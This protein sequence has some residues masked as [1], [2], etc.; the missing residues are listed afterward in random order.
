MPALALLLLQA[1]Q[2]A[3]LHLCFIRLQLQQLQDDLGDV[4]WGAAGVGL[5]VRIGRHGL[6]HSAVV[7]G[8]LRLDGAVGEGGIV[9]AS[10]RRVAGHSHGQGGGPV[11]AA[12]IVS[13]RQGGGV[14][15]QGLGHGVDAVDG[16]GQPVVVLHG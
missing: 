3:C 4:G 8:V 12:L 7:V 14:G 9:V 10:E 6:M 16:G 15:R 5:W 11:G 13:R 2:D 1:G